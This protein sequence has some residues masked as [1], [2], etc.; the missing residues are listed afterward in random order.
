MDAY[1]QE[2]GGCSNNSE[3]KSKSLYNNI[4]KSLG[5]PQKFCDFDGLPKVM[6]NPNIIKIT[7]A[8][9]FAAF[10]LKTFRYLLNQKCVKYNF[11]SKVYNIIALI[12]A[13]N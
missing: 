4:M 3:A 11:Y 6:K 7:L 2:N 13:L 9:F 5:Q 12:T 1:L 8:N 10:Y